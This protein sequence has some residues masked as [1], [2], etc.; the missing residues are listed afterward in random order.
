MNPKKQLSRGDKCL[1]RVIDGKFK[2]DLWDVM[3]VLFDESDRFYLEETLI[4]AKNT[5]KRFKENEI[6]TF[7]DEIYIDN[8][9]EVFNSVKR[10]YMDL[11]SLQ[12]EYELGTPERLLID[13]ELSKIIKIDL[14]AVEF[15]LYERDKEE[16][17]KYAQV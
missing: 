4:E 7:K 17:V 13:K 14:E 11:I 2:G 15:L 8:L 3:E 16:F 5:Y 9:E 10:S 12:K 1:Q 6:K